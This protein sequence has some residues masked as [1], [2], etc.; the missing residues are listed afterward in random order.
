LREC[1]NSLNNPFGRVSMAKVTNKRRLI[2][3]KAERQLKQ[4]IQRAAKTLGIEDNIEIVDTNIPGS[5]VDKYLSTARKVP[6]TLKWF[7]EHHPMVEVIPEENVPITIN[8]VRIDFRLD[9]KIT[10]PAPF[11]AEYE[12]YRSAIRRAGRS[13]FRAG[14]TLPEGVVGVI[15][16]A[17]GLQP[18]GTEEG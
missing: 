9:Q 13:G 18:E 2:S 6:F 7:Q 4:E 1:K 10:V 3:P 5:K 15:P 17:G 8:G 14:S 16:G 12:R 11:K